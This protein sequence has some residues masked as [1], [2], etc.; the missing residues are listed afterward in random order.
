[1]RLGTR[2]TVHWVLAFAANV[3]LISVSPA[4]D[5]SYISPSDGF[6]DEA[7]L[8]SL[9]EPPSISQSGFFITNA[10]NV[11]VTIDSITASEFP[12]HADN[13]QPASRCTP[14]YATNVLYLDNT[15]TVAL[16]I[17]DGLTVGYDEPFDENV[18]SSQFI[19]S[20]STLIVDG[21]SG[22]QLHINEGSM[23]IINS[24]MT[25][26]NTA[27]QVGATDF[28]DGSHYRLHSFVQA[29][30]VVAGNGANSGGSIQIIGGTMILSSS[31]GLG[32]DD[33]SSGGLD[34]TSGG[35]CIITNG[36]ILA[37][38]GYSSG[39]S[40]TVSNATLL[41]RDMG[42]V[43]AEVVALAASPSTTALYH[44]PEGANAGQS[45]FAFG[46][47]LLNGGILTVTNADIKH[48][49]VL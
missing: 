32:S 46:G 48:C 23:E 38:N 15:G 42:L 34:V 6:W 19:S 27:L 26:T 44:L 2:Q 7:R 21:V 33:T 35:L 22:G 10:A 4:Q 43:L 45:L 16:H 29:Q 37:G 36:T 39:G 1:M 28:A 8:W 5:N 40:V 24:S 18:T 20:N 17:R 47:V 13:E 25:V 30:Q 9:A 3:L 49:T 31:L 11:N 12:G 14:S 41:G